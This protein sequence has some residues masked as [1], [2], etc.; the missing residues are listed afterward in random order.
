MALVCDSCGTENPDQ[1]RFCFACAAPLVEAPRARRERKFATALFAD[2]VGS[3]AL[4]ER[5][6]PEVVQ[7]VI[8]RAFDRAAREIER[9]G[10]LLEKFIGDAILAVFG[11]PTVHEDDPERAVRAGLALLKLLD[12]LNEAFAAEGR[13]ELAMR[14]G[15]E[16]GEVL[17]D[18][19]R[20]EGPRHRMLTGDAVNTAARLEQVAEPGRIVVGPAV[21][22]ATKQHIEY[23]A[24]PPL[25]LKGKALP[26]PAWEALRPK[27]MPR[28]DR[29]PLRLE[30]RLVGRDEEL[31]QLEHTLE[32]ARSEARPILVTVLGPAGIGKSRL[33]YEFLQRLEQLPEPPEVRKGRCLSYGNV[34]YSALAEVVKAECEVLDDDPPEVAAAK[35]SA[36]VECLFGDGELIPHV[37]A[38]IGSG[39]D[40]RFGREDLFDAWRRILERM[41]TRAPLVLV[42]ED[43]HW[44]DDGL[45]DFV[46]HLADWGQ[47]PIL[48]LALARPDLLERR[49]SWGEGARG[50]VAIVLD[51]LT[52]EESELMLEHLLGAGLP[53]ALTKVVLERGEGNPL[54]AEEII[55]MLI[56]RGVIRASEASLWELIGSVEEAEVPRSI[57]ALVAA[58]LDSLP[59][60]EKAILQDASVIGRTF[61]AGA[62]QRLSDLS[63]ERVREALGGL[64]VKGLVALREASTW[65][66]EQEFAFHH[67]VIRDVAYDSL[68]KALR[69]EK[70][71]ATAR[72][73]EEQA[74]YRSDEIAELLATH[75]LQALHWLDELGETD[76]RR[77]EVE[78]EG[79][80]WSKAAGERAR[81]LWQQREAVRWLRTS[82]DLGARIGRRDD[83]LAPLWESYAMA[84]DGV[85]SY[86]DVVRA[87]EEALA[88]YQRERSEGDIGR[89]EASIA[90]SALWAGR[91]QTA[92]QR[93]KRAVDRLEPLG[94]SSDLAFALFALGRYELERDQ[95]DRAEPLLRRA[96][97]IADRVGDLR[98]QANATISLGWT[99]HARG[100]GDETVRLFDEA[101]EAARRAGDLS[102]LLDTLEAVFSAAIEV[103]GDYRRAETVGRE[104]LELSRRAGNVGKLSR[105][106]LNLAYLLREL[107][108]LDEADESAQGA[109]GSAMAVGDQLVVAYSNAVSALANCPRGRLDEAERAL[110]RCK[111][112]LA[113]EGIG[114]DMYTEEFDALVTSYIAAGR[115]HDE[116]AA[117]ILTEGIHRLTDERLSV[118]VGQ[119]LLFECVKALVRLGRREEA[120][121]HRDRL[122][123][124][125]AGNVPPRAFLA[126]A[127]GLLEPDPRVARDH[128]SEAV[129]RFEALG[130]PIDL[131]R[132]LIDLAEAE[133]RSGEDHHQTLDRARMEL[134]SC[135]ALLFLRDV[136]GVR[137]LTPVSP[138]KTHGV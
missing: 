113:E 99:L 127:D 76:G 111:A 79:Y 92:G 20:A 98:T 39:R 4:A 37:E 38:L 56:D 128:L 78:R 22:E 34:S 3:T 19:D 11:V 50:H 9:H 8:G 82:L 24:L 28:G 117:D 62:L 89:V 135:G 7:S 16:A 110:D 91:F 65:S 75:H 10:G 97:D 93:A 101:L 100:G 122:A 12:D 120:I 47:G 51:P 48:I 6:D 42:L 123:R 57:Q 115:G 94:E 23:R 1:A 72:W 84:S 114:Y 134:E 33:V 116:Q 18:L 118:W 60:E 36:T 2:L 125:A 129:A 49:P 17:V 85:E 69:A 41:A 13:P 43:L 31:A 137:P 102:L 108:R 55:R 73:A 52:P 14:I 119:L 25:E 29:A 66:G 124:L 26:V 105:S 132:C 5:E 138:E 77:R 103:L 121:P 90:H 88:R 64:Q 83:E 107:G 133:R 68:P 71:V 27:T 81:R 46:E 131:G 30:A 63:D 87:W 130:R 59:A 70:H 53:A 112:I 21:F 15:I 95:I 61:W 40:H 58:R 80:R 45:L 96:R 74:G 104:S 67:L 109:L 35:A 126:W 44:A 32:R 86:P 54:F 136:A 106:Q